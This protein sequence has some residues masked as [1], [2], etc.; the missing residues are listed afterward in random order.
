MPSLM[1]QRL[2]AHKKVVDKPSSKLPMV[3]KIVLGLTQV[4]GYKRFECQN[5]FS[6]YNCTRIV[7]TSHLLNALC[8]ITQQILVPV[9]LDPIF[10][11]RGLFSSNTFL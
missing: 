6:K 8:N 9:F 4:M 10:P 3:L 2:S 1:L 7:A 11:S 5:Y